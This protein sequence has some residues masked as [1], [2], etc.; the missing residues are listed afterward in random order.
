MKPSYEELEEQLNRSRRLCD[1]AL[2][3]ERVWET[4]MMQACGEDGP[5]SVADKF[6]ELKA[7]CAA[8][9]AENAGLKSIQAW[10]VADV[11]KSGA[12]RFESTKAAGF[13]TDDCLH[14]AVLV[15]LSK[16]QTPATDAFLAEVRASAIPEGYVLVPQQI[17][18]DPSDIESICS[19]CGD[20]HESGYGDFTDGLLWV[21]NIQRDDG[22][23]VHGLHISSA[24]YSEEGGVTVCEFAAQLRKGAAL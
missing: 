3:N 6:A 17:F 12:K 14:D 1:A 9:A 5:K 7:Q 10:A 18:L 24:D 16:L 15:M 22:S 13:D 19:Q 4:A 23:I 11:F 8:L 2:A 20:G 21:G